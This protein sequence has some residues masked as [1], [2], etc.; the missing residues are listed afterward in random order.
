MHATINQITRPKVGCHIYMSRKLPKVPFYC[1]NN[2]YG[3]FLF[4]QKL[5]NCL[6]SHK[7][8]ME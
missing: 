7:K 4:Q 1:R 6:K 2:V 3:S 5:E 8:R